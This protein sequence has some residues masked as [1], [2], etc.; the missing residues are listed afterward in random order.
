MKSLLLTFA[1]FFSARLGG[2][3]TVFPGLKSLLSEAEWKRA[4]LDRLSPDEIG[5]IDAAFIRH[6]IAT[7]SQLQG[8]LKT[9]RETAAVAQAAVPT[10]E[11]KRSLMQRFGLPV[12][13]EADWRSRRL[14]RE[15]DHG[16]RQLRDGRRVRLEG[17][18]RIGASRADR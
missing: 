11:Q 4:G 9:A 6:Q 18:D 3:Q 14:G 17:H 8:E 7:T 10:V 5:V 2:A 15:P 12:W 16:R 1:L 13:D